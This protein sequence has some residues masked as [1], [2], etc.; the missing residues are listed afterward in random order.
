MEELLEAAAI[1]GLL[2]LLV[3]IKCNIV[4]YAGNI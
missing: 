1:K 3:E 2:S 4:M